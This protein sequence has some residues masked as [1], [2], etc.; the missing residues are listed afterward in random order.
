RLNTSPKENIES[1][2]LIW[3]RL[4]GNPSLTWEDLAFLR[5]Q[6]NLPILLKGI[7]HKEDAKLAYENGMDGLIV[8]NHGGRQVDGTI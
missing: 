6:T 4:F 3:T 5:K 2:I 1:A 8:S 7:L